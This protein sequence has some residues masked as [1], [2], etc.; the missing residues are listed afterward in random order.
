MF[1]LVPFRLSTFSLAHNA[2]AVSVEGELD[3]YTSPQLDGMLNDLDGAV[4]HVLL[5]LGGVTF[6]DSSAVSLLTRLAHR[7]ADRA[8]MVVL[9]IDVPGIRRVFEVTGLERYFAIHD[10]AAEATEALLGSAL[11]TTAG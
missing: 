6:I 7:L 1:G 11:R 3:V 9:V 4:T 8:G 5:D 10:D 2:A